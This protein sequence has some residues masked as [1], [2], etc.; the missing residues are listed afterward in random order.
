MTT[1]DL[2]FGQEMERHR[3]QNEEAEKK[4]LVATIREEMRRIEENT[5][6]STRPCTKP[7]ASLPMTMVSGIRLRISA[8][9]ET[10]G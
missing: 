6:N 2:P 9:M 7:K 5:E 8:D 10:K 1:D 4:S 3:Q